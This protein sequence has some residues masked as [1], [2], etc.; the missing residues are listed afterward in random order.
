MAT[1]FVYKRAAKDTLGGECGAEAFVGIE[2]KGLELLEY[3]EDEEVVVLQ[4]SSNAFQKGLFLLLC[5][6]LAGM[7]GRN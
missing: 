4:G 6:F 3:T 5:A 2:G 7:Q 1:Q